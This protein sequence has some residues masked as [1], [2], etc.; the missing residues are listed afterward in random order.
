MGERDPIYD[1]MKRLSKEKFDADRARAMEVAR[2]TDDGGWTKHTAWHWSR[3]VD[4]HRLDYWPSRSK[5]QFKGAVWRGD[6]RDWRNP[7]RSKTD[8]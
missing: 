4:G 1:E 7:L 3:Q 2:D 8:T 5:Y 6:I